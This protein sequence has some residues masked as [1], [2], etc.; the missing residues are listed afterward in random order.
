MPRG[1]QYDSSAKTEKTE[2]KTPFIAIIDIY[3]K[4]QFIFRSK[5]LLKYLCSECSIR[6]NKKS[7]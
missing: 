4:A 3:L 1:N 5:N 2:K 6:F 7:A